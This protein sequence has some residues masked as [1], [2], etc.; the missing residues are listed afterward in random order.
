VQ[1]FEL[2]GRSYI[3]AI[4]S[5]PGAC[6]L[7]PRELEVVRKAAAGAANKEIAYDLGLAHSTV[8]ALLRRAARKLGVRTRA[9][10]LE[11]VLRWGTSGDVAANA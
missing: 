4:A 3:L 7:S 11:T 10:V 9:Q 6:R 2:D 5:P 1:R 8:R